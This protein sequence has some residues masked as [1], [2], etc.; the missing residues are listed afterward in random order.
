MVMHMQRSGSMVDPDQRQGVGRHG[1]GGQPLTPV[2]RCW[3]KG[4]RPRGWPIMKLSEARHGFA[5][6]HH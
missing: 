1:V 5:N 3:R 4:I 6:T 2:P